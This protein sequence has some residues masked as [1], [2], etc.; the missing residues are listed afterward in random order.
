V[1]AVLGERPEHEGVVGVRAVAET[2]QHGGRRLASLRL[3]PPEEPALERAENLATT[4]GRLSYLR[5]VALRD[6]DVVLEGGVGRVER[7][8]E[9]VAFEEVV[10][11]TRVV[12]RSVL[13]IDRT[14]DRPEAAVLALDPDLDALGDAGVVAALDDTLGEPA[15]PRP[16]DQGGKDTIAQD[17]RDRQVLPERLLL[18]R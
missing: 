14:A 4:E 6:A 13:R 18:P 11:L 10:V 7:V 17:E 1:D 2:D 16:S 5:A 15:C 12:G 9:L 8:L 3:A